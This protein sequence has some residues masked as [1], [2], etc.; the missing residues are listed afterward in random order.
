[1]RTLA[2]ILLLLITNNLTGQE[3]GIKAGINVSSLGKK[4]NGLESRVGYIIGAIFIAPITKELGL[5]SELFYSLQGARDLNIAE[6]KR[7]Y[8]Y[9]NLPVMVNVLFLDRFRL[10]FGGQ[11]GFLL[12]GKI[13]DP[14][15]N[16]D[17]TDL[18]KRIDFGLILGLGIALNDRISSTI[19]YQLG[20]NNTVKASPGS[21]T[22]FQN[23]VLQISMEIK[24]I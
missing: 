15:G 7:N 9:L 10:Q 4:D 16:S 20:L 2:L 22:K 19:R 5:Q 8:T 11:T 18:L 13:K 12:L 24:L 23:K 6:R 17:I 1:M 3:I 14:I 21:T